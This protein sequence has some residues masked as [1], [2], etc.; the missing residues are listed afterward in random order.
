MLRPRHLSCPSSVTDAY[1]ACRRPIAL[2]E[3]V[4]ICNGK[5]YIKTMH[6]HVKTRDVGKLVSCTAYLIHILV[7]KHCGENWPIYDF[8]INRILPISSSSPPFFPGYLNQSEIVLIFH[9]HPTLVFLLMTPFFL[10]F[11]FFSLIFFLQTRT[12]SG[13]SFIESHSVQVCR[14]EH[15]ITNM[16]IW[17]Q[18]R[19]KVCMNDRP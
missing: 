7:A 4:G 19:E 5:C 9:Y 15:F 12:L 13:F 3:N 1:C 8:F 10:F 6:W 17:Q 18:A 11:F 16:H 14:Y 2:T